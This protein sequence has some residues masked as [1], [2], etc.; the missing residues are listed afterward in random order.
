M[1]LISGS[2][3]NAGV[4]VRVRIIVI[5]PRTGSSGSRRGGLLSYHS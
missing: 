3:V 5:H 4:R 1:L 2:S